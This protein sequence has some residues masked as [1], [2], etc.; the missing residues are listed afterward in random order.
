MQFSVAVRLA[1]LTVLPAIAFPTLAEAQTIAITGGRV[2]PVSGPP[3]ANGIVIITNGKITAVGASVA[4]PA[5]ATRL[6]ATG[7]WV[8]PGFVNAVTTL[9]LNEGSG[10][11]GYQ[12]QSAK[13]DS[14]V[15]ASFKAWEG[16]N[17]A[18]MFI[19]PARKDGVTTVA[20]VPNSGFVEGQVGVVDLLEGTVAQMLTKPTVALYGDFQNPGSANAGARG[21]LFAKW[22]ELLRDVKAYAGRKPQYESGQSRKL[23][24]SRA[25]LEA[26]VPVVSGAVPLWLAADRVSDIDAALALAKE[27]S[28]KLVIVGGA[29]AWQLSDRLAAATVPVLVGAMNNIPSSFAALGTRQENAGLLRAAGVQVVLI[30]NGAG[31]PSGYN[32]GNLRYEAGN[33][34]AYGMKW[35]DALRAAT[36]SAAEVL[37]VADK[38]GS[39]QA[40][41]SAN[42]VI[43]SGDPFE[44]ASVAEHVFVRGAEYAKPTRQDELTTRY[45]RP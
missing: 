41:R 29:E 19:P 43:W 27:F 15:A 1:A 14:G 37:G 25:D 13:G 32:A 9:G 26:L 33:A 34:V 22:R 24:A 44:F 36:L 20:L 38:V 40:G 39:L 5:N 2:L 3:I 31:D 16:M 35:D 45:K 11:G 17:P 21:E 23:R 18:S 10:A 30:G 7:K 28:L 6:D 12:D 42:V 4:I 8:T